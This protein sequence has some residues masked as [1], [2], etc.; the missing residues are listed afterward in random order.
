[1]RE[2]EERTREQEMEGRENDKKDK[3]KLKEMYT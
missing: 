3:V 1:V 2:A